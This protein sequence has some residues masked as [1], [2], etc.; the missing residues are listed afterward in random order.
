M[1]LPAQMSF[2]SVKSVNLSFL[3]VS[4]TAANS[5]TLRLESSL[6]LGALCQICANEF[7]LLGNTFSSSM[8]STCR[9]VSSKDAARSLTLTRNIFE[10]STLLTRVNST[11]ARYNNFISGISYDFAQGT[12]PCLFD[13]VLAN[14]LGFDARYNYWGGGDD[15]GPSTCCN[16]N[17][18]GSYVWAGTDFSFWCKNS[19]C[20]SFVEPSQQLNDSLFESGNSKCYAESFCSEG[21][22]RSAVALISAQSVV[23]VIAIVA[24]V[25]L[26][27]VGDLSRELRFR[28]LAISVR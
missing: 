27:F 2:L 25:V 20:E 18:L 22:A 7:A 6:F 19:S 1:I 8:I 23:G 28:R 4:D 10:N 16:P 12:A 24:N 11:I 26:F 5:V 13:E 21:S 14:P 17:G 9:Q 3:Y 15:S